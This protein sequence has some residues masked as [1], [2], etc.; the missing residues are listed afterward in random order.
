M[1]A[2]ALAILATLLGILAYLVGLYHFQYSDPYIREVLSLESDIT[3]GQAIFQMNCSSC[4]GIDGGGLVGPNLHNVA[5]RKSEVAL[6]RQVISGQTPPM[7]Q[8]QP[9]PQTM[10]DLLGYLETL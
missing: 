7:P 9:E 4:H 10:A 5:D 8:F 3:H 6:I 2:I 1:Q